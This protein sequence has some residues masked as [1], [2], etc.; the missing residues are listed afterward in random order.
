M[1]QVKA[2]SAGNGSS[3]SSAATQ[4]WDIWVAPGLN[5]IY[6]GKADK[7]LLGFHIHNTGDTAD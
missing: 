1:F 3:F 4:D 2:Q 7:L 5:M 6:C